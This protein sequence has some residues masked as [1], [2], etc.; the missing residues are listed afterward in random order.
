V[1]IICGNIAEGSTL[2][3][4]YCRTEIA[5]HYGIEVINGGDYADPRQVI[6]LAQTAEAAGWEGLWVWD[7]LAFVWGAE[8]GDP[9]ITLAA[10]AASTARLR[11]GTG[12]TP[13]PRHRPHVLAHAL[14]T[15]DVLSQGRVIFGAGLGGVPEEFTAFGEPG[16]AKVRARMLDE[17]LQVLDRLWSG[18]RVAHHGDF[19]T[20]DGITLAP[21]PVQRPRIPIWIGGESLPA[22]RRAARWD[23]W[24]C[25]GVAADGKTMTKTPDEIA[26]K[27]ETLR[28]LSSMDSSPANADPVMFDIALTGYSSANDRGLV[29][30]YEQAG[31][32]W[33]LESLHG[34]RG[35]IEQMLERARAGPPGQV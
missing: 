7:H 14:A 22:L 23:G 30:E 8:F 20:V 34:R 21:L 35:S 11:L 25:G 10:V 24:I 1:L 33:W 15:L 4:K 19:Y 16:D 29:Q 27:V 2:R 6:R 32:T 13:L 26:N 9:W 18:E 5:M 31:V 3:G 17:G 12:V 28:N